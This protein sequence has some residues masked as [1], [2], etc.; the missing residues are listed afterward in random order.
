M[1]T[2]RV[3]AVQMNVTADRARNEAQADELIS[4]AVADGAEFVALPEN[5]DQI[6]PRED[7][8][9]QAE[10]LSG[11]LVTGYRDRAEKHGIWLLLGSFAEKAAEARIHNTSVLI[12]PT[13]DIVAVYRKIHL[14][15]ANPPDG[16][17][18]RESETVAPGRDIVT[19]Q[20]PLGMLGLSICYDLRFP[21]LYRALSAGGASVL[22][23]PSAFTVPTGQAHWEVLLRA[24]AIENLSYVIAPAQVG[25]HGHGRKSWGHALVI[26]P[27]GT[28]LAEAGG[29]EPG[30]ALATIDTSEVGRVRQVLPALEHRRV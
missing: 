2:F 12:N 5:A 27:W 29:S 7:R 1:N 26:D 14:F 30:V 15:D 18:Y 16:V 10:P 4:R 17:K 24:R 22:T 8:L 3:A 19:A 13:G 21:E 11:P 9:F 28:T 6:A 20:T 25:E 23:V